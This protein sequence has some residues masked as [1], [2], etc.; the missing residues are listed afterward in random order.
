M[1]SF[2]IFIVAKQ[3]LLLQGLEEIEVGDIYHRSYRPQIEGSASH[4][5]G[6]MNNVCIR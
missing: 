3:Q 6:I 2:V 4:K 1:R 5:Q